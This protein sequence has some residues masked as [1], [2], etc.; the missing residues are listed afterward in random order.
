M[1]RR[2]ENLEVY[3]KAFIAAM[4]I[5]EKTNKYPKYERYSLTDQIRRSSRAVCANIAE[6]Y[7]KRK[8]PKHFISK[9]TDAQSEASETMTWLRFSLS[10]N[11]LS[12]GDFQHLHQVYDNIIGKLVNMTKNPDKWKT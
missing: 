1:E 10:C 9:L 5:Y 4:I 6:A 2:V 8:Y 7:Y 12:E 11:Y 3:K